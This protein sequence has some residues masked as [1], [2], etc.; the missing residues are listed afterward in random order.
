MEN[1]YKGDNLSQKVMTQARM[2]LTEY[3]TRV[4]DVVKGKYGLKNREAALNKLIQ[5]HG[6]DYLEPDFD[7]KEQ[8]EILAIVAKHDKKKNKKSLSLAQVD[9]LLGL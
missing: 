3:S 2:E 7:E 8:K 6:V 5:I 1:V 9:E 4:L